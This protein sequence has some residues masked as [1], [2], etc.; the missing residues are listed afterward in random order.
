[1]Y[2]MVRPDIS[3]AVSMVSRY[4]YNPG[5]NQWLAVKWILRYLYGTVDVG[6]LFKNDCGQQCFGYCDSDFAGD[7]DKQRSTT[8][9]V[10]TLG[11]GPVS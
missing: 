10:F 6:L 2:A 9:Y 1:M 11:G 4:I 3:Q 7:F 5:K 8:G